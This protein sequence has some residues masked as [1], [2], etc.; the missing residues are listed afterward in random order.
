M[1]KVLKSEGTL[2]LLQNIFYEV[3]LLLFSPTRTKHFQLYLESNLTWRARVGSFNSTASSISLVS[4]SNLALVC[5]LYL[6]V[7]GTSNGEVD[8]HHHFVRQ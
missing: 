1:K 5:S 2:T 7:I 4:L 6:S 8:Y 3:A